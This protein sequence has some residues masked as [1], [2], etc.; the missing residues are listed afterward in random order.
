MRLVEVG[1][2]SGVADT[3][4]EVF[5]EYGLT[6]DPDDY[7]ADLYDLSGL[8][9]GE[10]GRFWVAEAGGEIVGCGGWMLTPELLAYP[11]GER[12]MHE[13][14]WRVGGCH[15][16]IIRMYVRPSARRQGI[17]QT[18]LQNIFANA[19]ENQWSG[20]E[21][22]SDKKFG[23]AHAMYERAGAVRLGDRICQDP[24]DSPEWGFVL[25]IADKK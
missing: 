25:P 19:R 4:R 22:W 5:E 24:D 13:G 23:A 6:W 17:A 1:D 15:A 18:I 14:Q 12:V 8:A 16:E 21:I 7:H 3:V 10:T 11:L 2:E 20:L 9:R